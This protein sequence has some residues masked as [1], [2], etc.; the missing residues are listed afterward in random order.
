MGVK[1]TTAK[2]TTKKA[3]AQREAAQNKIVQKAAVK[4]AVAKPAAKRAKPRLKLETFYADPVKDPAK[5]TLE[6]VAGE[7]FSGVWGEGRPRDEKLS[8]AGWDPAVVL[9]EAVRQRSVT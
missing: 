3:A 8:A 9:K 7:Y 2:P 1:K 5:K 6:E 4:K